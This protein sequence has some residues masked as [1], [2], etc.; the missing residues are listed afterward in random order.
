MKN[1]FKDFKRSDIMKPFFLKAQNTLRIL[2]DE[3]NSLLLFEGMAKK[4]HEITIENTMKLLIR[5]KLAFHQRSMLIEIMKS[6]INYELIAVELKNL[7][8]KHHV[9][10]IPEKDFTELQIKGERV[11][12]NGH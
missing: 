3:Q 11:F 5:C 4:Y 2:M 8:D 10:R 7:I 6:L 9:Y 1:K 12:D